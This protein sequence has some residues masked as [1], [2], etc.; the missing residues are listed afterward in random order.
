MNSKIVSFP[1]IDYS[2]PIIANNLEF[3]SELSMLGLQLFSMTENSLKN[4][5]GDKAKESKIINDMFNTWNFNLFQQTAFVAIVNSL[6]PQIKFE[7]D[8]EEFSKHI[9]LIM[10]NNTNISKEQA[11]FLAEKGFQYGMIWN[12][13]S[14]EWKIVVSNEEVD[15]HLENYYKTTNNSIREY[16]TN[17]AEYEKVRMN[18]RM[19]KTFTE[20]NEKFIV[21]LQMPITIKKKKQD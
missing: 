21:I 20:A 12:Y 3:T 17:N 7:M 15:E 5:R 18:L 8:E 2:K 4:V 16:K 13:F 19:K 11:R 1:D 6:I 9:E 10:K 14:N